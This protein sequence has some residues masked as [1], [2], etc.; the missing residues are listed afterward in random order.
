MLIDSI[1]CPIDTDKDG[2]ADYIDICP[3]TPKNVIVDEEGCPIDADKDGI[4]DYIDICPNTPLGV[5]VDENGCPL[6]ADKDGVD[7][8]IDKCPNTP[9][10]AIVDSIGCPLDS[11]KDNVYDYIDRCPNTPIGVAVDSIGCPFDSDKDGVADYIDQCPNTPNNI[12]VDEKG[13]PIDSD[14]DGIIDADDKCP[15]NAGPESNYGC[16]EIKKEVRNL[17]KKAMTGIQFE[18][19][20][21]IIKKISYPLL[22]QIVAIMEL[23]PEYHLTISGH[24]DSAGDDDKNMLLSIERAQAVGMYFIGKGIDFRRLTTQG[25]GETKPIA[26]NKTSKGKALN[27]RVEFEISFEE[28]TYEKVINPELQNTTQ[29]TDSIDN[30]LTTDSIK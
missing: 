3:N 22:D 28:V 11:D 13:C 26:D 8:Y 30:T 29:P 6:D 15:H 4:A 21:A 5:T 20:K 7:D 17:F 19:G 14:N 23:N 1:G 24:T 16:P 18:S 9:L 12:I 10:G 2:I 25:F 27:R